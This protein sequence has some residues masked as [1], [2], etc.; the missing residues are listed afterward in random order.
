MRQMLLGR[1]ENF[2][3]ASCMLPVVVYGYETWS[4]ALREQHRLR[5]TENRVPRRIF[6]P[7]RE[8]VTG[9]WNW[10]MRSFIMCTVRRILTE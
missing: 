10:I 7:N 2:I 6:V 8:G 1:F 5:M 3:R 9:N 4:L